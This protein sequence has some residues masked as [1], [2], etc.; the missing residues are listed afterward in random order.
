MKQGEAEKLSNFLEFGIIAQI[1]EFT[2]TTGATTTTVTHY[3]LSS[4][5]CV[6]LMPTDATTALEYG[7][8][9]TYVTPAKG[10]FVVT[11]PNNG[12]ARIYRYVFFSGIR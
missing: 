1:G 8:G 9:T 3:G 5:S 2:V 7:L 6:L 10:S 11:H 12:N 4:N